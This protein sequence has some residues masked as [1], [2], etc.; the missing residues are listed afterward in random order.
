MKKKIIIVNNLLG[1]YGAENVLI[2]LVNNLNN[3]KY[4]ITLLTLKKSDS[5]LL[6]S[7]IKYKYIFTDKNSI[8]AKIYNKTLLLLGYKILSKFYC[9]NYDIAIAFKM[10]ECAK[11][12]SF[13]NSKKKYCWIHSNV[14]DINESCFYSFNSLDEECE[15]LKKFDSLIAVSESSKYSFQKKYPVNLQIE[16][17]Y[18]PIDCKQI[19]KKSNEK[20]SSNDKLLL[21]EK[22]PIIGTIARI[23][24]NKGIERLINISKRLT[25]KN[26][27]HTLIIVGDGVDY[28]R[29]KK[30]IKDQK[31]NNI[32]MIGFRE[33][34]YNILKHFSLFVCSSYS[35][36][37]SIVTEEA[38]CLGI[39]VISTKCG[40]PEE[41]LQNGKY[42]L[43]V[44]NSE[45]AL[46]EAI[47]KFLILGIKDIEKYDASNSLKEFI[48][49]VENLF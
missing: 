13:C 25:N 10:G 6:T 15:S 4:D 21:C 38:L 20:L 35:E 3:E 24:A 22:K 29:C 14:S 1:Y 26:I 36:S 48:Y 45:D 19:I 33:N 5:S 31:L 42:G 49:N 47:E 17:I 30:K 40:G 27:D 37:Y 34:P 32:M 44:E 39:P 2:N 41:V 23:D 16:V 43:L 46:F 18:N 11:L 8:F 9:K 12:V 7:N 28:N